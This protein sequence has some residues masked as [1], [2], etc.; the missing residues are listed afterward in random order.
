MG[1]LLINYK[2]I[3]N[4]KKLKAI[5]K[6]YIKSY[7]SV[8][9]KFP[10]AK[11]GKVVKNSSQQCIGY[12]DSSA[13]RKA[14]M[15]DN[16][17]AIIEYIKDA[18]IKGMSGSGF[19]TANKIETVRNAQVSKKYFIVNAVACDPGLIHDAWLLENYKKEIEAGISI[20][21]NCIRFEKVIIA[22]PENV[23]SRYP[24]GAEKIL[25]KQL[26]GMDID[27]DDVTAQKGILVLNVQTVYA[28]TKAF[29]TNNNN[30]NQRFLT[31]AD[32][33]TGEARVASVVQG[34]TI[35]ELLKQAKMVAKERA[36]YA[37]MGVM[38]AEKVT[39]DSEI[40]LQTNIVVLASEVAQ[41]NNLAKCKGCGACERKCPSGVSIRKIVK[42]VEKQQK[43]GMEE[44]GTQ[45]CIGCGTCSYYCKAGKNTMKI[46]LDLREER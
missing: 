33:D 5:Q 36:I 10:K 4:N 29:E 23:P 45:N 42:A 44:Y 25:I 17:Q 12:T 30:C 40:T 8:K 11:L 26:L 27:K 39:K 7:K 35:Q 32:L 13:N 14:G 6:E 16:P 21:K 22:S 1:Q 28:I 41:F 18:Q 20:I 24:M 43:N 9:G 37:G 31:I 38:E 2:S 3:K 46:I 15:L 34:Q 19:P